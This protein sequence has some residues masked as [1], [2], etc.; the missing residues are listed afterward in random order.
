[1]AENVLEINACPETK[2][3]WWW[4]LSKHLSD[5]R[6]IP[7]RFSYVFDGPKACEK[8]LG[9]FDRAIDSEDG[10]AVCRVL[11]EIW[12]MAPDRESTRSIPGWNVLCDLCSEE[13]S[14]DE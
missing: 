3:Q 10:H 13:W 6:H 1:M 8:F 14:L 9:E 4:L 7:L 12:A 2:K 11:N 5:I